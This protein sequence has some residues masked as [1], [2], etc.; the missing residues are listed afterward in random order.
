[1]SPIS[2][3]ELAPV[4][5]IEEALA[6][7][8]VCPEEEEGEMEEAV[9]LSFVIISRCGLRE[10]LGKGKARDFECLDPFSCS[11]TFLLVP[12]FRYLVLKEICVMLIIAPYT[13]H[14]HS[15]VVF[16]VNS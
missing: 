4:D 7:V 1:M 15:Q 14:G 9:M 13:F 8:D 2:S 12:Q 6:W 16:A 10:E 3:P 5:G 11:Q